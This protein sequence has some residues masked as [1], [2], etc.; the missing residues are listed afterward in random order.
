MKNKQHPYY[1]TWCNM[2]ARCYNQNHP[3]FRDYGGRGID[4][5]PAWR[6]DFWQFVNDMG[7]RPDRY[8]LERVDN[9]LGYNPENCIWETRSN[10]ARNQRPRKVSAKSGV[11]WVSW[12]RDK[13][14]AEPYDK[15]LGRNR[16]I[17][18]FDTIEEAATAIEQ[19]RMGR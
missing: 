2:K 17:G 12:K 4:V 11:R 9:D 3:Q 6:H 14:A 7:E 19:H 18:V 10:Q 5:C 1:A 13:W 8:T 15:E 16:Y